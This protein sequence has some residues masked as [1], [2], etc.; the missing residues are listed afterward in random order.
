MTFRF[1]NFVL[2]SDC[3]ALTR[4]GRNVAI[5]AK[6]SVFHAVDAI[7]S[8]AGNTASSLELIGSTMSSSRSWR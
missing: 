7:S 6:R 4:D 5:S 3:R 8:A 2:D 1:G